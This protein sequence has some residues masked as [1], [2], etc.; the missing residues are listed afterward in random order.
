[1]GDQTPLYL[2]M[3]SRSTVEEVGG[4]S[5]QVKTTGNEKTRFTT[6]L[7]ITADGRKLPPFIL[8]RRKTLPKDAFPPGIHVRAHESGSFNEDITKDWLKTVWARRPGALLNKQSMLVLD[9]FRGHLT[10]SVKFQIREL[11]TDLV[12]IPGEMTSLL[13][14]L[15]VSVNKTFKNNIEE[16]YSD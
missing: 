4:K 6:M 16:L 8:F 11:K 3:P 2:D 9:S 13:Q 7:A 15:D 5:I 12:I 1:M 10:D 14:P